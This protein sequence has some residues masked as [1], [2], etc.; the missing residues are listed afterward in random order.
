MDEIIAE[1][2]LRIVVDFF[3][4]IMPMIGVM[5]GAS[6]CAKIVYSMCF[7]WHKFNND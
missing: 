6:F 1:Y 3:N 5:A 7:S 2:T 4:Q